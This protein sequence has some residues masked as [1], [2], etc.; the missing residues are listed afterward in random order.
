MRKNP[1]TVL[2]IAPTNNLKLISDAWRRLAQKSHPDKGGD[3]DTFLKVKEAY[4]Q[5]LVLA[6]TIISIRKPQ[7]RL[8][9][10]LMLSA[11]EVLAPQTKEVQFYD[12]L[13]RIVKCNVTIPAWKLDWNSNQTLRIIDVESSDQTLVTIDIICNIQTDTLTITNEGLILTPEVIAANAVNQHTVSFEWNGV[14]TINI[15]KYGQG[16]LYS[17]G[18]LLA[19]GTRSNILV[20]PKYVFN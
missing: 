11:S 4:E 3:A 5:A 17:I 1:W 18:Y 6:P 13:G 15:D 2:G 16:M 20:K 10:E 12:H 8:S 14:R 7:K 9:F 19:D